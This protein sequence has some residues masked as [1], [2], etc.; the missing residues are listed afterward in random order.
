MAAYI[1]VIR[2]RLHDASKL[3]PYGQK[4]AAAP[5]EK[6]T[7]L[8]RY[9]TLKVL[10]GPDCDGVAIMEFPSLADAE[11]WYDSSE[12]QDA[13]RFRREAGDYRVMIVEGV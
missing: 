2:E 13:R 8:A 10:E 4:A 5:R 1:V 6:L 3:E 11:A 7:R 12:Y 9:G